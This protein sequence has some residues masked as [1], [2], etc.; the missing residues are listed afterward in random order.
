MMEA[1]RSPSPSHSLVS[2]SKVAFDRHRELRAV[3]PVAICQLRLLVHVGLVAARMGCLV[4]GEGG[5]ARDDCD[6]NQSLHAT[7]AQ[8]STGQHSTAACTAAATSPPSRP[9]AHRWMSMSRM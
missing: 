4:R 2:A 3:P 9:W 8:H 6:R 5:S 1:K 7:V